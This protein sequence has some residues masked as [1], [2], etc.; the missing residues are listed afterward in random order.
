[1][2]ET[3]LDRERTWVQRLVDS[4]AYPLLPLVCCVAAWGLWYTNP[5]AGWVVL[6]PLAPL[7]LRLLAGRAPIRRT[8]L[9]VPL[10]VFLLT[11]GVGVWAGY[12]RDATAVVFPGAGPVGWQALW[13]LILA[14]LVYYA[15][16]AMET[17]TQQRWM[18]AWWALFGG[19]IGFW[20]LAGHDW[21]ADPAK[22]GAITR[23]GA[24]VQAWLPRVQDPGLNPNAAARMVAALLPLGTGLAVD[25]LRSNRRGRWAWFAWGA[26]TTLWMALALLLST[27]RGTWIG[28][29]AA[30]GLA[31]LWWLSGRLRRGRQQGR[32][33]LFAAMVGLSLLL[34][35]GTVLASPLRSTLLENPA[36]ANR[37]QLLSQSALLVRDYPFTGAGLG[38]YA[39]VHSTYA[40]LIHVPILPHGH[41][42]LM[43]IALSQGVLGAV[44]AVCVLVGAAWAG[45]YA[46]DRGGSSPPA[47]A[48]G[49]LS[50]AIV[51]IAGLGDDSFYSSWGV[52][53]LWVPA[54]VVIA[55]WRG[56]GAAYRKAL[57][58]GAWRWRTLA[59]VT[60]VVLVL[61][62]GYRRPL[63]AAWHANMGAVRQ[64]RI[65][66][67][68]YDH[69]HFDDPTLDQI[70][71]RSDLSPVEE[72]YRR[73]LALDPGQVTARTRLAQLDLA[74][75]AYDETLDHVQ[76][77]WDAG[78]RDRVTRLLLGDAL[79][80][81]GQVEEGVAIVRGLEWAAGRLDGQAFYRYWVG[82][83]YARAADAWRAELALD[84]GNARV[85]GAIDAAEARSREQ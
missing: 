20:F 16:A 27:S 2:R 61:A 39:L 75:G 81:T 64:T 55:G 84:P 31:A 63:A 4:E 11:A 28:V 80:A 26:I 69:R 3:R 13:G 65:E 70:R 51:S 19:G 79:V 43:D 68:Q 54:G 18:M 82:E 25:A 46:L 85:I 44:A 24:A 5:S 67:S 62:I 41:A 49:L 78:H 32:L 60:G 35:V 14:V 59:A 30:L 36:V 9:D 22:L 21:G 38:Q 73:A 71:A 56:A 83:D 57:R 37:L 42:Q 7:A 76:A 34:A 10:L 6:L 33:A 17:A 48:P 50:L 40:L 66:L 53:L 45:L 23:L 29:M 74:R 1:M 15:L 47:L 52:L 72:S 77:A 58:P 8:P 12:D